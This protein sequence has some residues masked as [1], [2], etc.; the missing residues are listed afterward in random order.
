MSSDKEIDYLDVDY[1]TLD[2]KALKRSRYVLECLFFHNPSEQLIGLIQEWYF[3]NMGKK[4]V[5]IALWE[6]FSK[7][8]IPELED[9]P[10]QDFSL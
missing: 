5:D 9:M 7:V 2:E 6:M 3:L 4:E 8:T 1:S 10:D